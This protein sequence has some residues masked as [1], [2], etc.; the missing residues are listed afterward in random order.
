MKYF[1]YYCYMNRD[2]EMLLKS[3]H[4]I[5]NIDGLDLEYGDMKYLLPNMIGKY[6]N[7]GKIYLSDS[8]VNILTING[9]PINGDI[10]YKNIF[11]GKNCKFYKEHRIKFVADHVVPCSYILNLIMESDKGINT[12]GDILSSNVVVMILKEED[13]RLNSMGYRSMITEDFDLSNN[14]W[15]RYNK[16]GISVS[17]NY[18]IDV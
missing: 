6:S 5:V 7:R 1:V 14:I 10:R 8:V 11:Y 18:F 13:D 3:I 15:G 2:Q 16:C 12:I 17:D 4:S 9:Y